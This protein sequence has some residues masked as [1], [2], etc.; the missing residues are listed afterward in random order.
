MARARLCSRPSKGSSRASQ[1][2]LRAHDPRE[3]V[4]SLR[5]EL[6]AI[7]AKVD[8]IGAAA[9]D[10]AALESIRKQVEET[11]GVLGALAKHAAP[12]DRIE[13]QIGELADRVEQLSKSPAPSAAS[14]APVVAELA[15]ARAQVE[16]STSG[17][18]LSAIEQRLEQIAARMDRALENPLPARLVSPRAFEDLSRRIDSVRESI[19]SHYAAAPAATGPTA[20]SD[21]SVLE[22]TLHEISAK[23][24]RPIHASVDP[25]A[26]QTQFQDLGERIDRRPAS[27]IDTAPL[28]QILRKLAERPSVADTRPLEG[29]IREVS[30]KL[31][32]PAPPVVEVANFERMIHDL[33]E[34]IS[35][36]RDPVVDTRFFE[37]SLR[38]LHDKLEQSSAPHLA[39]ERIDQAVEALSAQIAAKTASVD[40]HALESM[41]GELLHQL[42]ETRHALHDLAGASQRGPSGDEA[43]V[44][45]IEDLRIEQSNA[46]RRIQSALGG[47]H[48]MLEALVDRM[49][50][51]ED[52]VAQVA[53]APAAAPPEPA[54]VASYAA[55]DP[56]PA[57]ALN[58]MDSTIRSAPVFAPPARTAPPDIEPRAPQFA[59]TGTPMRSI[60]GSEFLMEPGS[61]APLRASPADAIASEPPKSAINAHIAAARRAAQAALAETANNM[62]KAGGKSAQGTGQAAGGVAGAK[63]FLAARRRPILLGALLVILLT[64]VVVELG[65]MR[66]P[67]MQKSESPPIAASKQTSLEPAKQAPAASDPQPHADARSVD[68]T[69][70]GSIAP[71]SA[72]TPTTKFLSPAPADLVAAIP[73]GVPQGLRE[74]AAAGDASAQFE[75]A[76]RLADGRSVVKDPHAA[77]LWFERAAAQSLAPAEYRLGSLYEKGVG[78]TRDTQLAMAWYKKAAEA[79]NAR[80]MHNLAVLI[81]GAA[82]VKPDYAQAADWFAKAAQL[83]VKDS[84]YNLAILYARGMGVPQDLGQS[85]IYFSL[86]AQQGDADAAKKRD[87]VAAKLDAK[88]I[89]LA[90]AALANFHASTPNPAA[91]EAPPPPGGWDVGKIGAPAGVVL[92]PTATGART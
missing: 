75:L 74:A 41:V 17:A 9:I 38:H 30:A 31:D 45:G 3:A 22:R 69:P 67:S 2:S 60:D 28:E 25:Q 68:A 48:D 54:A 56:A 49:G 27:T 90:G 72:S 79:G 91:N 71:P 84:Q 80:A 63:A 6:G 19:E 8:G 42:D 62:D 77:F 18:A 47:V 78:V 46:D 61:G 5:R 92:P 86:A 37:D 20:S 11:R 76:S 66:Q 13:R 64:A 52:E 10:P 32:R 82:S 58:S 23:L 7:G 57:A 21:V 40:T 15:K 26:F 83:G 59:P 34:R 43:F 16:G 89:A 73:P 24:D 14:W 35:Q 85:W 51:I 4:E 44:R 39:L 88:A 70:V 1:K 50:Q 12:L 87:E 65:V 81:A 29:L 53:R 33:G 36:Q 55:R